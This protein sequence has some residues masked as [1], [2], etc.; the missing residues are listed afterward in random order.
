MK[1]KIMLMVGAAAGMGVYM[2]L[3]KMSQN[4]KMIKN[5]LNNII[6]DTADMFEMSN[7]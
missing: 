7:K 1:D 2:G 3:S 5:K 4:R 6:D